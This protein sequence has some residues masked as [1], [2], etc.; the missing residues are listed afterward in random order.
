MFPRRGL[1]RT[2]RR[3][4]CD[5][6]TGSCNRCDGCRSRR[7]RPVAREIAGIRQR[8]NFDFQLVARLPDYFIPEIRLEIMRCVG[9]DLWD[10]RR[11]FFIVLQELV[12]IQFQT[13][14]GRRDGRRLGLFTIVR[15][16]IV[17]Y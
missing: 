3:G 16:M 6:R 1:F 2:G 17:I 12:K 5:G 8:L 14:L 11:L 10:D 15:L 4:R 9:L 7:R 13:I